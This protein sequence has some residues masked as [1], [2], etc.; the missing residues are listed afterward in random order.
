MKRSSTTNAFQRG[1]TVT[2]VATVYAAG[3][4]PKGRI[5]HHQT[6]DIQLYPFRAAKIHD[7]AI[8]YD[9]AEGVSCPKACCF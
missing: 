4:S 1:S 2:P 8:V 9:P 3:E 6:P 5:V 7:I